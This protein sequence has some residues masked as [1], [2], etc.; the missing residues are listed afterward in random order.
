MPAVDSGD[1]PPPADDLACITVVERVTELLEGALDPGESAR[2]RAHLAGCDGCRAYAGQV[3]A[4]LRMLATTPPEALSPQLRRALLA[5]FRAAPGAPGTAADPQLEALR[6]GDQQAFR[7]L[8]ATHG[9]VLMRLALQQTRDRQV[10]EE[11]LQETWLAVLRGVGGFEGRGSLRG[12]MCTILIHIAARRSG[13]EARSTPLSAL[14]DP[15][16]AEDGGPTVD[17]ARFL[18]DGPYAGHWRSFPDDWSGVPESA[19][20]GAE[21]RAVALGALARLPP[22][23]RTA[24]T[25]RDLE[26]WPAAEAAELLQ[27]TPGHLRVLL[28]R[29]R[30]AVR[31]ALESYLAGV[32]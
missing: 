13:R 6:A 8:V 23:Q 32:P 14:G 9:P 22:G 2:L 12:W 16:G 10:A 27:V 17:P 20:L 30:A 7:E 25:L 19:L 21:V 26:G 28:H 5:R 29:G 3:R 18:P 24:V 1:A 11:V 31:A 15:A 4:V